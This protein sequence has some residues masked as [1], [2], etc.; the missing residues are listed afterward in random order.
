[1]SN[2]DHVRISKT[3]TFLLRY[4]P[5]V[6]Q[7]TLDSQGWVSMDEVCRAATALLKLEV[8][9]ATLREIAATSPIQRFEILG[10]YIRMAPLRGPKRRAPDIL[11]HATTEDRLAEFVRRGKISS[12][13]QR[14]V[15]LS[16]HQEQAWLVAHRL[17]GVPMVLFIDTTRARRQGV[18]F[19]RKGQHGLYVSGP[20]PISE[21][22]NLQD[23]FAEQL[24]AG[25]LPVRFTPE[26]RAQ[27]ALI[28]VTRRSGVTWEVAKGKL[29]DGE[30]PETTAVR[31]VQEEMG[32]SA[33]FKVTLHVGDIRY[34]FLTPQGHPRLK[35][36]YLYLMEAQ[37]PIEAF[38][39]AV[40][41]GIGD[42]RWFDI[43]EATRSV[44]HTSLT[45]LMNRVRKILLAGPDYARSFEAYRVQQMKEELH[46][47]HP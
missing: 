20:I 21:V 37:E 46:A 18:R 19:S 34:S 2:P 44:T 45:P 3:V 33:S 42:V 25:G 11:Y 27:V 32:L 9:A 14:S 22:L 12:G 4:K 17:K 30:P 8:E 35:T 5:E 47:D 41:E 38:V 24:S 15:Y 26:G 16:S 1:M 10:D 13:S 23:N 31:E 7:L 39:P 6:G 43:D 28:R 40:G 36:V 29:E